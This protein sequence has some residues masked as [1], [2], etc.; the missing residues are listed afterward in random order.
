MYKFFLIFQ[1]FKVLRVYLHSEFSKKILA[2]LYSW[3][4]YT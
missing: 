4:W 2:D 3:Q 1:Y